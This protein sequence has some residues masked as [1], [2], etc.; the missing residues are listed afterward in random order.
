MGPFYIPDLTSRAHVRAVGTDPWK[1]EHISIM[2]Y[3]PALQLKMGAGRFQARSAERFRLRGSGVATPA[4]GNFVGQG[5]LG[6]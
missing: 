1:H 3:N 5:R 2:R 4:N 6:A